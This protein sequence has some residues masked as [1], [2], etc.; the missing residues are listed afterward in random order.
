VRERTRSLLL[1]G[2][3]MARPRNPV[4]FPD[5]DRT[6]RDRPRLPAKI[7]PAPPRPSILRLRPV[8]GRSHTH[9]SRTDCDRRHI[10]RRDE[11]HPR[12]PAVSCGPSGATP[13]PGR[14]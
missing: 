13:V 9:S 7:H 1:P 6:S 5:G 12:E 10:Q 8:A 2:R 3:A 11:A 4:D 14:R